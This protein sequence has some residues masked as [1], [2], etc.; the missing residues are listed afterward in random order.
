MSLWTDLK[1][2]ENIPCNFHTLMFIY[3]RYKFTVVRLHITIYHTRQKQ[4]TF[5]CIFGNKILTKICLKQT[6][7]VFMRLIY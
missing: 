6:F 5:L 7:Y 2:T 4:R 3:F 1:V